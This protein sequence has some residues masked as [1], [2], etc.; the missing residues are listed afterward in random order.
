MK[1]LAVM[2]KEMVTSLILG[3]FRSKIELLLRN[4]QRLDAE[5]ISRIGEKFHE[6]RDGAVDV[7]QLFDD[8]EVKKNLIWQ[9]DQIGHEFAAALDK[10]LEAQQQADQINQFTMF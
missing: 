1:R 2:D 6:Y 8:K 10:K 3:N 4:S 5:M 7:I 9:I